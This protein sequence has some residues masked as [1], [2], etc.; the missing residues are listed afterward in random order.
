MYRSFTKTDWDAFSGAEPFSSHKP[1]FIWQ[2]T[3]NDGHVDMTVIADRTGIEISFCG[4]DYDSDDQCVF[5]KDLHL[6]S[7]RAEGELKGLISVLD[8]YEYAPDIS[9]ELDHPTHEVTQGFIYVG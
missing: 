4:D 6:S 1:P 2:K 8:L 9:Y 3:L 5:E 7:I